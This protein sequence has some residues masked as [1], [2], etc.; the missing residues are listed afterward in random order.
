MG[1]ARFTTST[2]Q[3]SVLGKP[4]KPVP[5]KD[6]LLFQPGADLEQA[7]AA[8]ERIEHEVAHIEIPL[9]YAEDLYDL[10]LHISLIQQKLERQAG[11]GG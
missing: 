8:L 9:S 1:C 5:G 4:R 2:D 7:R 6:H 10:R 3:D 11:E